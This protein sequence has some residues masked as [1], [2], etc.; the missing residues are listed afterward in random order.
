MTLSTD[1]YRAELINKI[2]FAGSQ[3]IV[4]LYIETAIQTLESHK[5]NELCIAKFVDKII[6][7]LNQFSPMKKNAQQWS[8]IKMAGILFTRIQSK[9]GTSIS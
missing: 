5:V 3:E 6:Y 4:K 2:L 7:D 9:M 1:N 8:N